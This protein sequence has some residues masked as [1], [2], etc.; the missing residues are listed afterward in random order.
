M[1]LMDVMDDRYLLVRGC[2]VVFLTV[3]GGA[4][5]GI[6]SP[7]GWAD[8]ARNRDKGMVTFGLSTADSDEFG[9]ES[10]GAG[11]EG[12]RRPRESGGD[13]VGETG[14]AKCDGCVGLGFLSCW[15]LVHRG[16]S[17]CRGAECGL[18]GHG[19]DVLLVEV[20]SYR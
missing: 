6:E 3:Q 12:R 20:L 17:R 1:D 18:G 14:S 8:L 15:R 16:G 11:V 19:K 13:A 10:L 2:R 4:D 5:R 7:Q 9:L